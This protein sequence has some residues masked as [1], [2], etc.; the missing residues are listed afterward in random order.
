VK[1]PLFF[2][3]PGSGAYLPLDARVLASILDGSIRL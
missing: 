3:D 2:G 1:D